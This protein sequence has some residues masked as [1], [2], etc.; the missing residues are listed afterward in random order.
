MLYKTIQY[1]VLYVLKLIQNS[2]T[3]VIFMNIVEETV[4]KHVVVPTELEIAVN[5]KSKYTAF[6]KLS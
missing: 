1:I 4:R 3:L 2:G 5:Q 6:P